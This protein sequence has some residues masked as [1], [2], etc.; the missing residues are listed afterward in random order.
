M[1]TR[2]VWHLTD[3]VGPCGRLLNHIFDLSVPHIIDHNR[4]A[5]QRLYVQA[6]K[7]R[8]GGQVARGRPPFRA[9]TRRAAFEEPQASSLTSTNS[10]GGCLAHFRSRCVHG[11][12]R[13]GV[14]RLRVEVGAG[15]QR[16]QPARPGTIQAANFLHH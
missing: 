7:R 13:S 12:R 16:P 8:R 10:K 4:S 11:R 3:E 5:R 6:Q 9:A 2:E 1:R 14:L 15:A